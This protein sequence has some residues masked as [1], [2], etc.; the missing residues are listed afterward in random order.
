MRILQVNNEDETEDIVYEDLRIVG[1]LN[2]LY[3]NGFTEQMDSM[4]DMIRRTLSITFSG[5]VEN[6]NEPGVFT[7]EIRFDYLKYAKEFAM[8]GFPSYSD[9]ALTNFIVAR[10][11]DGNNPS[12]TRKILLNRH[13][14]GGVVIH[15]DPVVAWLAKNGYTVCETGLG[16]LLQE[17]MTSYGNS[18][19]DPPEADVM[20][21]VKS[22]YPYKIYSRK[23]SATESD[24]KSQQNEEM[25]EA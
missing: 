16:S 10:D 8:V 25:D 13:R 22:R 7:P 21:Y 18:F 15:G 4:H 9:S 20:G 5:F 11:P 17:W 14:L 2:W 3:S 19:N 12:I 1:A 23:I 6:E 24:R